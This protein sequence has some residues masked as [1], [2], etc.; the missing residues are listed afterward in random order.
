MLMNISDEEIKYLLYEEKTMRLRRMAAVWAAKCAEKIS[1]HIFHRQG[2]TWAGKLAL[3]IC[4]NILSELAA[5]VR[6]DIFIVCGTNGKTTTNNMLCA[7]LEA[8]GK[9]VVC[10]HTG[11]NMLNGVVAAFALAAGWGGNLDADYASIEI[12]EASTRRVFPYFK[13]GYMVLTNLFRDQLDR[14]GEIDIT[15]KLLKE[16]MQTAPDMKVIVNG[17][18]ALSA[19]L[20]MDA[21]NGYVTYGINEKVMENEDSHEIREGRFC[22]KCGALLHYNFYHY[23]QLGDY[24]CTE[25]DFKRPEIQFPASDV[26][27]GDEL[28]FMA[29]GRKI[30]ANYKGFYNVYNIL[31]A[32][33]AVR[34]AGLEAA[35]FNDMLAR[36]NPENGRMEK[37]HIKGT[38][39][40]LNLA[41]NPAGF[42]QNISAVMQDDTRKDTI[43]VIN[44]NGQDGRDISWLW[45]VDFDRFKD[46]NVDSIT[47]SGIRC[48]DMRLRL[49]YVDIPSML[50]ADVETAI[51][52]RVENGCG[53]LYVL[54]NYT[55][56]FSTRVVLKRLEGSK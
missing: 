46:A 11:S 36:F 7:A 50:E 13:P 35:H 47:V 19:F 32:Y 38:R 15:M 22:K 4:P 54:V 14:Y 37:F 43:I 42:N 17:D 9:K 39:V 28:S 45:D 48:Q 20:A 21:G 56:L 24:V 23:S 3:K 5:Q 49:K 26:Q 8:E 12:D 1:V 18:D 33:T 2:V 16:V 25:C 44:D 40:I 27:V 41:K 34:S 55:A 31:A 52:E 10:N 51:C 29:E 53:N 6:E 30:T